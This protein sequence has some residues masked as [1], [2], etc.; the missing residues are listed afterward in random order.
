MLTESLRPGH[1]SGAGLRSAVGSRLRHSRQGPTRARRL[2]SVS[3]PLAQRGG[4]GLRPLPQA[5]FLIAW[6]GDTPGKEGREKLQGPRTRRWRLEIRL[7]VV[8][9][10]KLLHLI[11]LKAMPNQR[12]GHLPLPH[13]LSQA[14]GLLPTPGLCTCALNLEALTCPV[15]GWPLPSLSLNLISSGKTP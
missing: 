10:L 3:C 5:Q 7:I 11:P 6:S 13:V 9:S 2:L 1:A 15:Q 14:S 8:R 12:S 4:R